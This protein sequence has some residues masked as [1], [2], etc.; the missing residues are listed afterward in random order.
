MDLRTIHDK[1]SHGAY[2]TPEEFRSDV[3]VMFSNC[4]DYNPSWAPV[5]YIFVF[6]F[7]E[8][9]I[10]PS[11]AG[12]Q[13][14][15][16]KRCSTRNGRNCLLQLLQVRIY[17]A[18]HPGSLRRR[19]SATPPKKQRSSGGS[20]TSQRQP[21]KKA[22]KSGSLSRLDPLNEEQ[23]VA[24]CEVL[25]TLPDVRMEQVISLIRQRLPK[26][27]DVSTKPGT[28]KNERSL[29]LLK[30]D[31][32]LTLEFEN[33]PAE[34]QSEIFELLKLPR[35]ASNHQSHLSSDSSELSSD[36]SD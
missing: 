29:T 3:K 26:Y 18:L 21:K 31:E 11:H 5:W 30:N 17:L 12:N 14:R 7:C 16:W 28:T 10:S 4:Y 36:D 33:L 8:A 6:I 19:L 34:L 2:A 9:S 20:V 15:N 35:P 24:L 32:T 1:L 27:Q 22:K 23:K 25:V 13:E